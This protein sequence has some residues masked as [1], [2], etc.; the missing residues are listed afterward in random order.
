MYA[1]VYLSSTDSSRGG[2]VYEGTSHS[3]AKSGGKVK[4]GVLCGSSWWWERYC[5]D[6]DGRAMEGK[7]RGESTSTGFGGLISHSGEGGVGVGAL[8][9]SAGGATEPESPVG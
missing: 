5:S 8:R 6:T 4:T 9:G 7:E 1:A 3:A 2:N